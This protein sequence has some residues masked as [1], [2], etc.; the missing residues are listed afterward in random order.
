MH[1]GSVLSKLLSF[2]KL[3]DFYGWDPYDGLNS[4]FLRFWTFNS[5]KLRLYTQQFMKRTPVNMRWLFGV[6]KGRNP[7]GM[8]L[9]A[10][11]YIHTFKKMQNDEYK[12]KAMDILSWLTENTNK[13]YHG[14]CWGYN[15]DWQSAVFF[16]PKGEPTVVNTSFI[17]NVFLDAYEAFGDSKYLDIARSSCD[18]I[19]K[20]LHRTYRKAIHNNLIT[21]NLITNDS[22]FCFS[23]SPFDQ[24]VTHNANLLAAELLVRVYN[25]T[26]ET[27]LLTI[28]GKAVDFTLAHF[29]PDGSIYQGTAPE[30]KFIDSF[31]TGFVL[32]SLFNIAKYSDLEDK[33][34]QYMR[35]MHNAYRYYK[36]VFFEKD[37]LPHYYNNKIYPI[38]LHCSAQGIITFLMFREF[39]HGAVQMANSIAR[40]AI[41]NMWDEEKGYFYFQKTKILTNKIPY[42]R[43]PNIWMFYALSLL[44]Y[45]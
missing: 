29:N 14:A 18:F 33:N 40:W 22:A 38:D 41:D 45:T 3:N 2:I 42:L 28:A 35:I 24:S 9:L 12:K 21:N 27:D 15:F 16:V 31:H 32:V 11:T 5:S 20:D 19:L 25:H 39:D 36:Q 17:A 37:G 43:W 13:K 4:K 7:K 26:K 23:Y 30:Q 44:Q 6:P 10:K 8:G 34:A 1:L